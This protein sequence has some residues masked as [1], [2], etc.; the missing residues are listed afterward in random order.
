MVKILVL[1][2]V[3]Q[4]RVWGQLGLHGNP[5]Q[6]KQISAKKLVEWFGRLKKSHFKNKQQKKTAHGT[7]HS[8]N[9]EDLLKFLVSLKIWIYKLQT[10]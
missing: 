4:E 1:K 3:N 9:P 2:R 8:E 5:V 10:R 7:T 6:T